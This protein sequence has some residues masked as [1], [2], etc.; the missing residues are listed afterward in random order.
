MIYVIYFF[1]A[2]FLLIAGLMYF[3]Y[4]RNRHFGLLLMATTYAV[5]G[6]LAYSLRHWWPL[7]LG[8]VLVWALRLLGLEPKVE[9]QEEDDEGKAEV[10]RGKE[11]GK[12][13]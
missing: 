12:S 8:F 3:A 7:V 13:G 9:Y 1:A 2:G 4:F 10:G 6:L 5:S 11:E